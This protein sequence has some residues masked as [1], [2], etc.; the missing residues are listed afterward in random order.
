MTQ[1]SIFISGPNQINGQVKISGSKNAALPLLAAATLCESTSTF[2]NLPQII[3]IEYTCQT[4]ALLGCKLTLTEQQALQIDT[5]NCQSLDIPKDIASKTRTSLLFLGPL[6]SRFG[7]AKIPPS[8]GC[9]LGLRP[10]DQHIQGL[11]QMGAVIAESNEG[12]IAKAPNGLK[13]A[14]ITLPSPPSVTGTENLIMA[15]CLA[16]GKT[17]IHNPALEPE[18]DDLITYLKFCGADIHKDQSIHI[19]G[20][21][22]LT[23]CS[24]SIMGDRL[25]AGTFLIAATATQGKIKVTGVDAKHLTALIDKLEQAGAQIQCSPDSI[26]LNMN[27]R[28][29]AVSISTQPYPGFPTDLQP[30]WMTLACVSEG[31]ST[32]E[33]CIFENR[34]NHITSLLKLGANITIKSSQL[35]K[36]KGIERLKGND[37]AASD[38]RAGAA[39]L[40]AGMVAQGHSVI[41]HAHFINRGHENLTEK[42]EQLGINIHRTQA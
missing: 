8:G 30:Q 16:Q 23:G 41:K 12:I 25:E 27:K 21:K 35:I 2:F 29:K 18:I 7:Q 40:I 15:A 31:E 5:T 13:G 32:I 3:D 37:L 17:I 14:E 1:N 11:I 10:I 26:E 38:I 42:L 6:L 36:T 22:R 24:Y 34:I 4:L 28:P 19:N 33:E 20:V 9:K 39:L